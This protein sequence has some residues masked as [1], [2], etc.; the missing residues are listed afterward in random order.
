MNLPNLI[1]RV[2]AG[3]P[4]DPADEGTATW[5]S[6]WSFIKCAAMGHVEHVRTTAFSVQGQTN[7]RTYMTC[8]CGKLHRRIL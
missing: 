3:P 8:D 1:A 6:V 5:G 7:L 4:K 2:I